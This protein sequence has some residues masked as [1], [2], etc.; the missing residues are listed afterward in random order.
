[1]KRLKRTENKDNLSELPDCVLL[2]ILS[3]LDTKLAVQTC[4]LSA[5]WKNLWK[6]VPAL[7]LNTY[8]HSLYTRIKLKGFTKFV[9][10]ILSKRD[11]STAL[12]TLEFRR[13]GL[14][15]P[16]IFKRILKYAVS[17]NVQQLQICYILSLTN[18]AFHVGDNGC[19]DPFSEF[20][21]LNSLIIDRC[22]ALDAENLHI[23]SVTLANL[24]VRTPRVVARNYRKIELST[25]SLRSFVF[26]GIPYQ[27][28][29]WSHLCSVTHLKIDANVPWSYA[30]LDWNLLVFLSWL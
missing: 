9:S 27:K 28:L 5:R 13:T 3:F 16:H 10:S 17:H 29:V 25:A 14:V 7:R 23:S 6:H 22:V 1:M 12:H 19:A 2:H 20:K 21:N 11:A 15:E 24:T 8:L 4:I 18:F 26:I 30:D